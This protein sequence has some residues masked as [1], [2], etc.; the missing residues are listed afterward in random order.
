MQE[1]LRPA[2]ARTSSYRRARACCVV[3][4]FRTAPGNVRLGRVLL[5]VVACSAAESVP[6]SF[7]DTSLAW[8]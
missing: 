1:H 3:Y 5:P 4:V 7:A 2:L 6:R 8:R